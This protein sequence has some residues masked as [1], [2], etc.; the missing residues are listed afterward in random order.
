MTACSMPDKDKSAMAYR[1]H[2]TYGEL[3][4]L[5]NGKPLK[6]NSVN[7]NVYIAIQ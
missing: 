4:K 6:G 1:I 2:C 3:S 5:K 7:G